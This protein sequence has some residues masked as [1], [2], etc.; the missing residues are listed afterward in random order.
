MVY[1][2]DEM[3]RLVKEER[4]RGKKTSPPLT[5]AVA[6]RNLERLRVVENLLA[7]R[8]YSRFIRR[9]TESGLETDSVRVPNGRCCLARSLARSAVTA[10]FRFSICFLASLAGIFPKCLASAFNN[11]SLGD[12]IF[13]PFVF[14]IL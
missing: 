3:K 9:L 5:E 10:L 8:H 6:R 7:E 2:D 14:T 4:H 11:R 12:L 13:L 1:K